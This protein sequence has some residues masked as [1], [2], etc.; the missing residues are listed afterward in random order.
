MDVEP[1]SAEDTQAMQAAVGDWSWDRHAVIVEV[2]GH[3]VAGSMNAMPHGGGNIGENDFD[4][5]FCIHFQGSKVHKNNEPCDRHQQQ[6]AKA[7]GAAAGQPQP[8]PS[9]M[10]REPVEVSGPESVFA[11]ER[12][13]TTD[14]RTTSRRR[15]LEMLRERLGLRSPLAIL[16]RDQE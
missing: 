16:G 13:G 14:R 7:A 11:Q 10:H 4:G 9:V 6:I 3:Q 1:A 5:H 12:T 2:N 8:E 15:G